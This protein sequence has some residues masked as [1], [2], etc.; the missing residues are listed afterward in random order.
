VKKTIATAVLTALMLTGLFA[1][2]AFP[3]HP[4]PNTVIIANDGGPAPLCNPFTN[5]NC[6]PPIQ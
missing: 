5:P 3:K 2:A 4:A 1:A 6:P